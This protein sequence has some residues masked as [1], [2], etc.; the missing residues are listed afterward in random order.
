MNAEIKSGE[1]FLDEA[2][3][4]VYAD[5]KCVQVFALYGIGD[6]TEA[7]PLY[8]VGGKTASAKAKM[9]MDYIRE[10]QSY[11]GD[12]KALDALLKGYG[13]FEGNGRS[14][15]SNRRGGRTAGRNA[16][17]HGGSSGS[18]SGR[19]SGRGTENQRGVKDQFSIREIKGED[20]TDYGKGVYLDS[21][22]LEG[23]TDAERKE[24]MRERVK[25]LGGQTITAYDPNG[26]A[27]DIRIA[28]PSEKFRNRNGRKVPVTKD[29]STKRNGTKVK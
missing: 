10:E 9:L 24:M 15:L 25:E 17:L 20:G 18:D 22:L 7:T 13:Y 3:K 19:A 28:A 1:N 8:A 6:G 27:V 2:T 14:N 5:E 12:R 23:L 11:D 26:E 29:L 16:A 4:W 21:T